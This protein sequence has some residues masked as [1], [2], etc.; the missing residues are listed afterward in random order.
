MNK[1]DRNTL[2][3]ILK[4]NTPTVTFIKKNG[5]ERV[6]RCTLRE[7]LIPAVFVDDANKEVV[8]VYD[9]DVKDWRSFRM[10]S[11]KTVQND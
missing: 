8:S 7:D 4:V 9:L 1:I 2:I 6:M 11:I 10:D 3:E 5:S